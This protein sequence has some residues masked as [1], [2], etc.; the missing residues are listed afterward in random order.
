MIWELL[1]PFPFGTHPVSQVAA[2]SP[3][4][5]KVMCFLF[6]TLPLLPD[7]SVS[8]ICLVLVGIRGQGLRLRIASTYQALC[9]HLI[10]E[11]VVFV[12]VLYACSPL[13]CLKPFICRHLNLSRL[14]KVLSST[15]SVR[16]THK[17]LLD[18]HKSTTHPHCALHHFPV[19]PTQPDSVVENFGHH[20]GYIAE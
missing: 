6:P 20:S 15:V 18:F 5:W 8:V 1:I 3:H 2:T 13:H 14:P 9:T 10:K 11:Q 16:A 12:L 17:A 7:P 4:I 19:T